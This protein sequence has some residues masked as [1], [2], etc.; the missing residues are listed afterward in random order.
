MSKSLIPKL[1]AIKQR[2]NEVA[3]LIIQP[4]VISDQ[5]RYSSLNKEYSDLGKIV[6]VYDQYKGALDSIAE[7]EE[8]I[9]DGSDRDL[10]DLAKEEKL[11]AQAKIPGLEEELKVLLIPK[12]PADDKNVI[13]ELRAG[14]GGDEAAIFVEDIYRMYTMYFKTKGWRHEVT[15][16][17]EAAKGYKELIM[18]VEGEGVYG[19]M[20]FESGVHRV[21]RVPET[22]SQGRVHTSAIT[23]AVLPEAEE[24]DFELNPADIEMQTSRSGGAGGQNVNKVETKVQLTH[25]PSGLVVVCQ[26][27]RSQLANRELAM[28]ML[29]TK[30]YDIELQKVQG[31]IAA[32]RK[33]MVS[34][35]DRSAKIKT[36]N[37]PQGRVTDHR[38]NKSM[39]NLDAYMNGDISEMI[40]AVIMAENAEKMKG[41][42]ENY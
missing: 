6:R 11:E 41:E 24:V 32:Q 23:V 7:S 40:D 17:N 9:A 16:S 12:D 30:L 39:Y 10:V 8:I 34:T 22:E 31:D 19:I 29:R 18:K 15:D 35:G 4:D 14:T 25:K 2:Y 42:E 26:Q 33:S 28:E 5:K 20:K 27:A 38:I 36:Y 21:Q 13:V 3:D 37:Y 1:E